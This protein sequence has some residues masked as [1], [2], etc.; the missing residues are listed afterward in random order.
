[1]LLNTKRIALLLF[2]ALL[3]IQAFTQQKF[4][5]IATATAYDEYFDATYTNIQTAGSNSICSTGTSVSAKITSDF[6]GIVSSVSV[7]KTISGSGRSPVEIRVNWNSCKTGTVSIDVYCNP[8]RHHWDGCRWEGNIYMYTYRITRKRALPSGKLTPVGNTTINVVDPSAM[9]GFN[10][11]YLPSASFP[12]TQRP[13]YIQYSDAAGSH[14]VLLSKQN[15]AYI[16]TPLTFYANKFGP[17]TI[18]TI[19]VDNC[20]G[21][22]VGPRMTV[23]L[24]PTCHSDNPVTQSIQSD[25]P[26]AEIS[27]EQAYKGQ[28]N[29]QYNIIATG[30]ND[31]ANNYNWTVDGSISGSNADI[32]FNGS[33]FKLLKDLG[34]YR[35]GL[36]LKP[37]RVGWC[38]PPTT[39]MKVFAGGEDLVLKNLCTIQLPR[40]FN[41]LCYTTKEAPNVP[42]CFPS[43]SLTDISLKHFSAT[44]QS[45]RTIIVEPGVTLEDGAELFVDDPLAAPEGDEDMNFTETTTYDEYGRVL[46]NSR[47]YFDGN[48][49]NIQTQTKNF[50]GA[51][52]IGNETLYDGYGRAAIATLPAPMRSSKAQDN[53]VC[54]EDAQLPASLKFAYKADFVKA[55]GNETYN[56]THFDLTNELN[57]VPVDGASEGT[58]GWY[59]S[60]NNGNSTDQ[61]LN[62]PLVA[63]TQYPYSRTLFE[64]D[65]S[66]DVKGVTKPGDVFRA[67]SNYLATSKPEIVQAGDSYLDAYLNMRRDELNFPK[68]LV[69]DGEFYKVVTKD[70]IGKSSVTYLDR[71][72]KAIISLLFDENGVRQSRSYQFYDDLGRLIVNVAP[73]GV[74]QYESGIGFD[75]IDKTRHFYNKKGLLEATE[76][77]DAGTTRFLYRK[78]GSIRF[79]QNAEQRNANPKRYSYTN[80][81]NA[82]RPVESGECTMTEN[83]IAFD[84][85]AMRA[86]MESTAPDG[87][88]PDIAGIKTNRIQ[89]FYDEVLCPLRTQR[90]VHGA[91]SYT[92]KENIITTWYSYDERGRVEWMIQ[93]ITGLGIKTIDYR[94]GPTGSVQEVTYQKGQDDQFTHYYEYDTDGRLFKAYTTRLDLT[95]SKFGLLTNPG[96]TYD[97]TNKFLTGFGPL[98]LQATY[99]YYLHGPLKRVELADKL[100]GIDYV[101]TVQGQL[102]AINHSDPQKDPG[103]DGSNGV[104]ADVFGMTLDYFAN[105]YRGAN[106]NIG[107]TATFSDNYTDQ[108]TGLIKAQRWHGPVEPGKQVGYAYSY[109]GKNQFTNADWGTVT[110]NAFIKTPLSPY[111]ESV[112]S[113]DDNGNINSL[114]RNESTHLLNSDNSNLSIADFTYH[115]TPLT[116]Q[117]NTITNADGS[118]FRNYTYNAIGQ[119]VQTTEGSKSTYVVY[120]V[121]GKV[122]GVFADAAHTQPIT[123]FQYDDRG[124]RLSKTTYD[125]NHVASVCTWYV[126]D[127][128]GN[129]ISTY[130][131]DLTNADQPINTETVVY[132]SGKLGLYKPNYGHTL[133]ELTDHLG[134]VRAVIGQD[135][136]QEYMATMEGERA[137]R[138]EQDGFVNAA[139]YPS[140]AFNTT[141]TSITL[142]GEAE[143][144]SS[145]DEVVMINNYIANSSG[146][147]PKPIGAGIM[148]WVHPGDVINTSVKAHYAD[149]D[150]SDKNNNLLLSSMAGFLARTFMGHTPI[151]AT[152][153]FSPMTTN[154][155]SSLPVWGTKLDEDQPRAFLNYIL[156]DK[157]N[158]MLDY[159][160]DQVSSAAEITADNQAPETLQL[161]DIKI[162]KEGFIYIYV[163]SESAQNMEVYFDDL[164]VKHDYSDIVAGGDYYPYGLAIE[165][166]Q[167]N[168][169]KYRFGYQ[170]GYS[171]KDDETG[172]N[173]FELREYDPLIGRWTAIDP[174]RQFNTPYMGMGNNPVLGV[175]PDGGGVLDIIFRNK[176]GQELG[177]I[178]NDKPDQVVTIN[179]EIATKKPLIIDPAKMR[180]ELGNDIQALGFGIDLSATFGGG[181][182]GGWEFVYYLTG[183]N[184]G[185]LYMYDKFGGNLGMEASAGV[186][187]FAAW[188]S[189]KPENVNADTWLGMFN[190]YSLGYDRLSGGYF[191]G[192]QS[193]RSQLWPGQNGEKP[194]WQGVQISAALI[195]INMIPK[196][197]WGAKWSSQKYTYVESLHLGPVNVTKGRVN[198]GR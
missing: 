29:V 101:Y 197:S 79:S 147:D 109:D 183:K 103:T 198:F 132:G 94:Y 47:S 179:T 38:K 120:D 21:A 119:T 1:M 90:Y 24:Y 165:D 153:L 49:K 122:T 95:Y 53:P 7:R 107:T 35:I 188:T 73:N 110:G 20:G 139:S 77:K 145:P 138:E 114:Q 178:V 158:K 171:E 117:L 180:S 174:K 175:D 172:W 12:F 128:S 143:T 10:M 123:T 181:M 125:E 41:L 106:Y 75:Q 159:D 118:T 160:F 37:D 152:T 105:D 98:E 26:I 130:E 96:I 72:K 5:I 36:S 169:D 133:Y 67:G 151:D 113:Y 146:V 9:V 51:V 92:K 58:L 187:G 63:T 15:G 68:P 81:D 176:N 149:F 64:H 177:R 156:F 142:N 69:I 104:R 78:D 52:V 28:V 91:V 126:R 115:Y 66:G 25:A 88:I 40:D 85:D 3:S 22:F 93:D 170:G 112:G 111:K 108:Y 86:V 34:S 127:A 39:T 100:Q 31:I 150:E 56:Y 44:V 148:L 116:N 97:A 87:G 59:Y 11:T 76:E 6:N 61:K 8:R 16:P 155:F 194:Y 23:Y 80:Y 190:S 43:I 89:S 157:D 2:G 193:G 184:L 124:F 18:N 46:G 54:P 84:S 27:P 4:Y 168:R 33:S 17:S 99:F 185:Q 154:D 13:L 82:A 19:I 131:D 45:N 70:E 161:T 57:P 140:S 50:S 14:S 60:S 186:Y 74:T 121:T 65:G 164:Y 30:F 42:Q 167:I 136:H 137:G 32:L 62:E 129:S 48:G 135:L 195:S 55:A 162:E 134:N 191:W 182:S 196:V 189:D 141:P 192:A 163:S 102:K 166:R 144:I 71:E 173:H 83:G